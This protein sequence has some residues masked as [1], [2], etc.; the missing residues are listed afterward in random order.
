MFYDERKEV[1]RRAE[2]KKPFTIDPILG[3]MLEKYRLVAQF[4]AELCINI[5]RNQEVLANY[6]NITYF[7]G[8]EVPPIKR[9]PTVGADVEEDS[10]S[11]EESDSSE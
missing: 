9:E 10:D 1:P 5:I 8:P 4:N 3:E 6:L 11:E 7:R 2:E